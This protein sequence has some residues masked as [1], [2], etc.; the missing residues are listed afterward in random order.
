[1]ELPIHSGGRKK[2]KSKEDYDL[3]KYRQT[4][5]GTKYTKIRLRGVQEYVKMLMKWFSQCNTC[6][7]SM[8][9]MSGGAHL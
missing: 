8:K 6:H 9:A 7:E 1:M 4:Y 5:T 2:N 3:G